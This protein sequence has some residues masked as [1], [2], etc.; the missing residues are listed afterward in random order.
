[1]NFGKIFA[2]QAEVIIITEVL[3]ILR[4]NTELN[5][6]EITAA[7]KF[8]PLGLRMCMCVCVHSTYTVTRRK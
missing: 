4:I 5:T 1:M 2:A 8:T 3:V 7:H 6:K